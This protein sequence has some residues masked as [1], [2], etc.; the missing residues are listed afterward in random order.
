MLVGTES[1]LSHCEGHAWQRVPVNAPTPTG[2]SLCYLT[3]GVVL[4]CSHAKLAAMTDPTDTT[5]TAYR[6]E[7]FHMVAG[8][9]TEFTFISEFCQAKDCIISHG[10]KCIY[11]SKNFV[12]LKI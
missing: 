7:A 1:C 4:Q 8:M 6:A 2:T 3:V 12:V 11:S 9:F 5:T 10:S